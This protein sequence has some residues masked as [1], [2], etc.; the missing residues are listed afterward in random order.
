MN[1]SRWPARYEIWL[2]IPLDGRWA[3]WFEGLEVAASDNATV[4]R[5][6]LADDAALHGVLAKIRDL[7]LPL[8]SV[9]R[10]ELET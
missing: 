4:L 7:G 5:G 9:R 3:G 2:D 6:M 1:Q 8:V 10:I